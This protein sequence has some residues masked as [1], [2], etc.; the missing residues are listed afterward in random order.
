MDSLE[1]KNPGLMLQRLCFVVI[2]V[3][4]NPFLF[5]ATLNYHFSRYEPHSCLVQNLLNSFYVDDLVTGER[6]VEECLSLYQKSKKCLSEGA[7]NLRKW[8]SN[9]PKLLEL[10]CDDQVGTV[11]TC[12]VVKDTESYA[13]TTVNHLELATD[14]SVD[15]FIRG[16]SQLEEVYQNRLFRTMPK[17]LRLQIKF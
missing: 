8:I 4:A 9:S 10:I 14:L 13:K 15:A 6:G 7:F 5:N 16:D 17:R 1:E 12:A 3:N 2:G 11:G